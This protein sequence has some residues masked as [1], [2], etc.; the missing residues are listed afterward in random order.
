MQ[1]VADSLVQSVSPAA[2]NVSYNLD[3]R[4][5][6]FGH[7]LKSGAHFVIVRA[8]NGDQWR[9][10]TATV[11]V[12]ST[13]TQYLSCKLRVAVVQSSWVAVVSQITYV[14]LSAMN[15]KYQHFLRAL[16]VCGPHKVIANV[17]ESKPCQVPLLS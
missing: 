17:P 11:T 15:S 10:C 7:V 1:D 9:S 3:G 16:V 4:L 8:A 5:N 12:V 6:P 14:S 13:P 2:A